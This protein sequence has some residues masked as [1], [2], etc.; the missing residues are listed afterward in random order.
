MVNSLRKVSIMYMCHNL[1]DTNIWDSLFE[2]LPKCVKGSESRMPPQVRV[3]RSPPRGPA[4][5]AA[6]DR[7][8]A[9]ALV[10]VVRALFYSLLWSLHELEERAAQGAAVDAEAAALRERLQAYAQHCR[11]VAARGATPELR[12]EAYT[13]LCDLLVFF[14]EQLAA[15]HHPAL[16]A[17]RALVLE[18]DA[19]LCDLLNDFIQEFVFVNH[20]YGRSLR[21]ALLRTPRRVRD[22]RPGVWFSRCDRLNARL[23]AGCGRA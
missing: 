16:P 4:A 9:Q 11:D 8:R 20:N 19:P 14:A 21:A 6:S 7:G 10:F 17:A 1:N 12:E 5:R 22:G 13:S 3:P 2:D 15:V 23:F 18:P